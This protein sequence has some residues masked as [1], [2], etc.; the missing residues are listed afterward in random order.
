MKKHVFY[1]LFLIGKDMFMKSNQEIVI[2]IQTNGIE[3]TISILEK[4]RKK[5]QPIWSSYEEERL[6]TIFNPRKKR[7]IGPSS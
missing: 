5:N 3:Y 4:I 2:K 6:V 7:E 1:I